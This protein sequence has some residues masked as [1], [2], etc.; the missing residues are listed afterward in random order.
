MGKNIKRALISVSNKKGLVEF[1]KG[2]AGSG[3]EIVSTGGTARHLIENGISALE[4]SSVTGFPEILGGRVKTLHPKVFG[5]I[6]ARTG[7]QP[8]MEHIRQ[9]DISPVTL[10]AVN[11]YPF[12]E[13][14]EKYLSADGRAASGA[15]REPDTVPEEVIENI[16]IGGVALLRA[17]AKNFKYVTVVCDPSDYD[18]V[19]ESLNL[20]RQSRGSDALDYRKSLSAK[21]FRYTAWYDSLIA[22]YF[23]RET[24]GTQEKFP[25]KYP[26]YLQKISELRYGENPHQKAAIYVTPGTERIC[27]PVTLAKQLHGRELSYNNYLDLDAAWGC[28]SDFDETQMACAIIKH[29]N[30]CGVASAPATGAP[31]G[32]ASQSRSGQ[33]KLSD[34]YK[35]ALTCD[36]VS[37]FGGIIAFNKEVDEQTA[38]EVVKLFSECI[39]APSYTDAALLVFKSKKDLRIMGFQK[40]A[41]ADSP[42]S[43]LSSALCSSHR[44]A[45]SIME[46]RSISGGVL[47]QQKDTLTGLAGNEAGDVPER[48]V[49]KRKPTTAELESLKFAWLVCK[50]AKSNAIILVRGKQTTGIG[51]GQMSR[52]DSLKI[53]SI[54]M[55]KNENDLP[56][57]VKS[58]PLVLASDAFFPFRDVIDGAHDCGVT[59]I[60]QPGGSVKDAES[61]SACNEH[62]IAMIFTGVRHFRH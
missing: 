38:V 10:V 61:I 36:P 14:L 4:V 32:T 44:G 34:V 25:E 41:S 11:L 27:S 46:L 13:I 49:T 8:D 43:A 19:L 24:Q 28:V 54:K 30:P 40:T 56:P 31:S 47:I 57:E 42:A 1:A 60:V 58:S 45:S 26:L 37:A 29:T 35:M 9:H 62:G 6:L 48:T 55:K 51:A 2:L 12:D 20:S 33:T 39:I 7:E 53:A 3:F 5:G 21:A 52:I 15:V 59:A 23:T 22:E 18:G 16:D 50:N 17:A